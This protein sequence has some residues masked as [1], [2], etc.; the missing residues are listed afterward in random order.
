MEELNVKLGADG[1]LLS[2]ELQKAA[3]Q[4]KAYGKTVNQTLAQTAMQTARSGQAAK[5]AGVNFQGFSRVMQDAAFGPG[6]IANNLE[7][8]GRDLAEVSRISKETGQSLGK[9]LVQ[10]LMGGGGVNLALG[11]VTLALSLASYGLGAWTRM[12]G[13]NKKAVKDAADQYSIY[14]SA[15]KEGN[16]EAGKQLAD[17]GALYKATTNVSNSQATRNKAAVKLIELSDG[18]FKA[19]DKERLKNGELGAAY[20]SLT[21]DIIANARA[22]ALQ[23]KI[24]ALTGQKL[25][26]EIKLQK[27]A[28][29]NSNET[30]KAKDARQ[31]IGM[32]QAVVYTKE[33]QIVASN[34]RAEAATKETKAV[35]GGLE[36]QMQFLSK[37]Q[38][39]DRNIVDAI[40]GKDSDKVDNAIKKIKEAKGATKEWMDLMFAKARDKSVAGLST[41]SGLTPEGDRSSKITA[42]NAAQNLKLVLE[43]NKALLSE[44]AIAYD[45]FLVSI[46][47]NMASAFSNLFTGILTEGKLNF[48][49][50]GNSILQEFARILGSAIVKKLAGIFLNFATGGG[51]GIFGSIF[52]FLGGGGKIPGFA[53]GVENFSGGLAYVHA[54]EV[55]TN[56]AP[57]TSVIPAN[58]VSGMG[59]GGGGQVF[60]ANSYLRNDTIVTSY[61]RGNNTRGRI[62]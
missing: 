42:Q 39:A 31:E 13:E 41:D 34:G 51:A 48:K 27:I 6:A 58:Q 54:G 45:N 38:G 11:A 23:D 29:K 43:R 36:K 22:K 60:I 16:Q 25:D 28:T 62:I 2:P 56:L 40:V 46:S 55:L 50:L 21:V 20:R 33:Q 26:A 30:A 37:M 1:R 47:S 9:T 44:S 32:G 18:V 49:A 19:S 53:N 24:A 12:F 17:L 35:I 10:S 14:N 4:F 3:D 52:K 5:A 57:G 59:G 61:E 8:L 7:G 15:I